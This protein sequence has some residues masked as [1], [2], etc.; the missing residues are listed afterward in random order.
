MGW[1]TSYASDEPEPAYFGIVIAISMFLTTVCQTM[2]LHQYFQRCFMTGMRLRSA[3]V[4]AI[5]QKT[6]VLSNASRQQSTVGEIVNHMS[7]DAQ[8]LMDLCTYFHI[9]K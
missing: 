6:L 7:V 1:V 8:R 5:Y 4:T 2:F 3:L 9:S